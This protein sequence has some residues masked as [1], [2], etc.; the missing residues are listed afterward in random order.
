[1]LTSVAHLAFKWNMQKTAVEAVLCEKF[2]AKMNYFFLRR[3]AFFAAVFLA[4]FFAVFLTVRFAVF[5]AAL[6]TVF[7]TVFFAVFFAG[8]RVDFFFAGIV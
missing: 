8:L 4:G 6:R 1:M 5:L 7:F 3:T 2:D